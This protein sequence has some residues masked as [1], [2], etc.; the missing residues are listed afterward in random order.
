MT[1]QLTTRAEKIVNARNLEYGPLVSGDIATE[2]SLS[3]PKD[4]AAHIAERS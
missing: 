2:N 1:S 4:V 3:K